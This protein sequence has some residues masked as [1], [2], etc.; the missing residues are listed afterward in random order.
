MD[1][2][3]KYEHPHFNW[4]W[5]VARERE[6]RAA[7]EITEYV[8]PHQR[9]GD[10]AWDYGRIKHFILKLERGEPVTPIEIDDP[11]T[12]GQITGIPIVT[13][14][15]HRF[16]AHILTKQPT[17][18]CSFGGLVATLRWLQGRRKTHPTD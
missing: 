5:D 17:I 15:H 18:R 4:Q 13:D 7:K 9:S 6:I 16:A 10:R 8:L 1:R 12:F 3:L 14:G 2:L 11:C